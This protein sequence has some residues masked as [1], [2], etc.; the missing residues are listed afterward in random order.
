MNELAIFQFEG[1]REVRTLERDGEPWFVAKDVADILGIKNARRNLQS[2]P[3]DEKG[4]TSIYTLGGEQ[5]V[6]IINEPG[7]YRLIFQSRKSEAETFKR[8]VFHEVLPTIRKKGL[9]GLPSLME[10]V[11]KLLDD[12]KK[13][14]YEELGNFVQRN[15]IYDEKS[16]HIASVD[17]LY[18]EYEK[19]AEKTLVKRVFMFKIALDHPEFRL[20]CKKKEW[21][22]ANC[23]QEYRHNRLN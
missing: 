19:Q 3:E 4:V 22:F 7:M 5:D 17:N 1:S 9:Y 10:R 12:P 2:F 21:F 14:A 15:M 23:Q 6:L 18:H 11:E 8:W 13:T 20:Y 16:I